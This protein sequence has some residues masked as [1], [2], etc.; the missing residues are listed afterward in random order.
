[1][2]HFNLALLTAYITASD[3][4]SLNLVKWSKLMD[5]SWLIELKTRNEN[6]PKSCGRNLGKSP[7][8]LELF[9]EYRIPIVKN[10]QKLSKLSKMVHNGLKRYKMVQ[11]YLKWSTMVNRPERPKGAKDKVKKPEDRN[12]GPEGP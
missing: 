11:N 9:Y 5:R 3:A 4:F 12:R 1:M 8:R 6:S 10:G 2:S 7:T